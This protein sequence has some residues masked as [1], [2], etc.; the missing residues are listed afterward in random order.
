MKFRS[1]FLILPVFSCFAAA[2]AGEIRIVY[3]AEGALAPSVKNTFIFGNITPSTAPFYINGTKVSVYRNGAFIAYLPV[4]EGEF[5]FKC[6]LLDDTT[7]TYFRKIKIRQ[8]S[9]SGTAARSPRLEL[10]SPSSDLDLSPG[11]YVN[12]QASGTPGRTAVF[13]IK[14]MAENI[15]MTEL[16]KGS[17]RYFGVYRVKDSD[18]ADGARLS[19]KFKT[20]LFGAGASA[21]SGGRVSVLRRPVIVETST[22]SVILRN[23]V[24][25]G[26]MMFLPKGVRLVSDGRTG[27]SR[28]VRLSS[29]ET[30]WVD[31]SKIAVSADTAFPPQ[32]ETGAIRLKKTDFGATASIYM[33][34]PAAYTAEE[35]ENSLRLTLYYTKQH[36][37]TVIYDS[38]DT[39]VSQ[40]RFSQLAENTVA[41]D[42][43]F[44]PGA[45]L[46]GYDVYPGTRA[47]NIDLKRMPSVQGLWPRPLAGLRVVVDPG[48]SPKQVP[49]YDGAIGPMGTFEYQ[50]NRVTADKLKDTLSNLGATVFMTRYGDENVPLAD[51]P[52]IA[53]ECGGDIYISL[54]NNAVGDGEDPF[55][56]PRGFSVYHYQ[57]HSYGLARAIHRAY[58]RAIPLPDEGLRFGDYAVARMTSMPA[59]LVE[60]A[61]LILPEQEELLN[62]PA[63][64]EKLADTIAAGVLDFFKVNPAPSLLKKR[65][66]GRR[67]KPLP[68]LSAARRTPGGPGI[69]SGSGPGAQ[70][71]TSSAPFGNKRR[72]KTKS[73]SRKVKK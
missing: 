4:S 43:E 62:T 45:E 69:S 36:T 29:S 18:A 56:Q 55:S 47:L 44:A 63:F 19:V 58:L 48:H 57:R 17:G 42:F 51:R 73:S 30:G 9:Q 34:Y 72:V 16:P 33:P 46:G 7:V 50:V 31:D 14:N 64:Q 66:V 11:D 68:A 52:R 25:S 49:P 12:V 41:V 13:T 22:D 24:D 21:V 26:Y 35:R 67:G 10:L 39:F 32:N 60:S 37:N 38:S 53:K 6:E 61:Y 1:F 54:H 65:A 5:V 20:G 71:G 15:E 40:A 70:D 59:V 28:R 27:A 23:G 3:P 2:R 8:S